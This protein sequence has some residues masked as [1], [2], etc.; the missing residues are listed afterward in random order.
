MFFVRFHSNKAR[1]SLGVEEGEG[2]GGQLA[3]GKGRKSYF[4]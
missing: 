2:E 1:Q 3:R 4:E